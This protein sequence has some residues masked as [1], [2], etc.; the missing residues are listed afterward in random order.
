M[1]LVWKGAGIGTIWVERKRASDMR[2][3][4]GKFY[5]GMRSYLCE[6]RSAWSHINIQVPGGASLFA[7]GLIDDCRV[8]EWAQEFLASESLEFIRILPKRRSDVRYTRQG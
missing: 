1:C 3:P 5:Q 4:G 2:Q 6:Q 7:S 8:L